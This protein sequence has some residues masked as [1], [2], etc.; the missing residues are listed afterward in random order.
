[1]LSRGIRRAPLLLWSF[2][3]QLGFHQVSSQPTIL[4]SLALPSAPAIRQICKTVRQN[5]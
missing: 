3:G 2:W 1:M 5:F 4:A